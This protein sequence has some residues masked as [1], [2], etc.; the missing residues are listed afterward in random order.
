MKMDLSSVKSH[1]PVKIFSICVKWPVLQMISE[2]V[3]YLQIK[4]NVPQ[5]N[6]FTDIFLTVENNS[7]DNNFKFN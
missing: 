5:V 4:S 6:F 2:R 1:L 3:K 7:T